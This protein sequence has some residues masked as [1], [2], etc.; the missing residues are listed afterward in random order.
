MN[1]K[2]VLFNGFNIEYFQNDDMANSC[3][4]R[5]IEWEPH[6]LRFVE[7]YKELSNL[8]N[9]IDVGAN[10]GYHSLHFS[11]LIK[12]S[13][14]I[15]AFE[16]QLQNF[17]LLKKNVEMNNITN[18]VLFNNACSDVLEEVNMP[19]VDT[20][21]PVNMGDFTPNVINTKQSSKVKTIILD[22]LKLPKIDLIKID[23]Q[24]YEIK[25]LKGLK[26]LINKD[27]PILIIELEDCSMNKVNSS[28]KELIKSIRELGYYIFLLDYEYPSDHLCVHNNNLESFVDL[29]YKYIFENKNDNNVNHNIKFDINKKLVFT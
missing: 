4:G 2:L 24:G 11:K 23:V 13:G 17:E 25:V 3:I 22:N 12:E 10:F 8:E 9:I 27:K 16:P 6:I 18:V 15:F 28:C 29:F 14:K 21:N 26:E 5:G 7:K 19:Y 1:K 20:S